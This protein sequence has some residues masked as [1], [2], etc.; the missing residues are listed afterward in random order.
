M[1]FRIGIAVL[2]VVAIG[3][4]GCAAKSMRT[5]SG[6]VSLGQASGYPV[7]TV[8]VVRV[9][10]VTGRPA[11][12]LAQQ[13]QSLDPGWEAPGTHP[14]RDFE[15][16]YDPAGVAASE[17]YVVWAEARQDDKVVAASSPVQVLTGGK[18]TSGVLLGLAPVDT[19]ATAPPLP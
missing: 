18:A 7:G 10:D 19:L 16:G 1:R 3:L 8:L 4:S 14:P 5:V 6:R 13:R 12:E 11:R 9:A 17:T 2:L 15:V